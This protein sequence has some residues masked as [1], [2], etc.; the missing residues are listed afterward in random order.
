M[1]AF[2]GDGCCLFDKPVRI[3]S[4]IEEKFERRLR[5]ASFETCLITSAPLPIAISANGKTLDENE[6]V[7]DCTSVLFH[8]LDSISASE[9]YYLS[10]PRP[11][12]D[13]P[14][15]DASEAY[16]LGD[17]RPNADLPSIDVNEAYYLSDPRP[18]NLDFSTPFDPHNPR[19]AKW[20]KAGSYCIEHMMTHYYSAAK[21]HDCGWELCGAL[22]SHCCCH[23]DQQLYWTESSPL[24]SQK[25][26]TKKLIINERN[27][28]ARQR[29]KKR[30]QK[31]CV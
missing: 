15:I 14:S 26:T 27:K 1:S 2:D 25:M 10:D 23:D 11:N 31:T 29:R 28:K 16:Y 5:N 8:D 17:P 24:T 30:V 6:E 18:M 7:H 9:A 21:C 20:E 22:S 19:E 3:T 12:A 4:E 13:L